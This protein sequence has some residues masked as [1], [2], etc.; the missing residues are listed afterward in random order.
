MGELGCLIYHRITMGR[1]VSGEDL[2]VSESN[3][4]TDPLK[5]NPLSKPAEYKSDC[6]W[7]DRM[8]S[9]PYFDYVLNPL[10]PC[11]DSS[12]NNRGFGGPNLPQEKRPGTFVI[13]VGGGSVAERQAGRDRSLQDELNEHYT[14]E[15]IQQ[16]VVVSGA[17]AAW[18]QPQAFIAF[19]LFSGSIDGYIELDGFNEHYD[20]YGDPPLFEKPMNSHFM[21]GANNFMNWRAVVPLRFEADL[22]RWQLHKGFWQRSLLIYHTLAVVRGQLRKAAFEE[23]SSPLEFDPAFPRTHRA[24]YNLEQYKRY[25]RMSKA[26][27]N[28]MGIRCLFLIQPVPIIDKPLTDHEKLFLRDMYDY[29]TVY[30]TMTDS[31]LLLR[32]QKIPI[33]STLDLF[34]HETDD[35]YEDYIHFNQRGKRLMNRRILSLL[36]KEWGLQRHN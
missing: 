21:D 20:F 6:V 17:V 23:S 1:W 29:R 30:Q 31:L 7:M 2:I 19:A 18:K 13:L 4:V 33:Y 5:S 34:A 12:V 26:I 15:E 35:I 22:L 8:N 3:V 11:G 14:S 28:E 24:G 10:G 16:F 32:R 9:H 25:I 36:E 27:A